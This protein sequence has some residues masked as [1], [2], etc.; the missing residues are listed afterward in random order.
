MQVIIYIMQYKIIKYVYNFVIEYAKYTI[1]IKWNVYNNFQT[2]KQN[3][4]YNIFL[5]WIN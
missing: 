2:N 1:K 3:S 4:R 5:K